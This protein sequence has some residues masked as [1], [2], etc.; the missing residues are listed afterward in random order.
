MW[1]TPEFCATAADAVFTL[2]WCRTVRRYVDTVLLVHRTYHWGKIVRRSTTQK[3]T[4]VDRPALTPTHDRPMRQGLR[5][6]RVDILSLSGGASYGA[7]APPDFVQA[8]PDFCIK[9]CF[10]STSKWQL[11]LSANTEGLHLTVKCKNKRVW[12]PG[13]ART[14]WGAYSAPQIS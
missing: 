8:P 2:W 5:V 14:R 11:S 1:L 6:H 12:R 13:S 9:W 10:V 3:T 4:S 7:E